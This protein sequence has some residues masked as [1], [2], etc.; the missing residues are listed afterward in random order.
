[1]GQYVQFWKVGGI[2]S[3]TRTFHYTRTADQPIAKNKEVFIYYLAS[4]QMIPRPEF[5]VNKSS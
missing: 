3:N 5:I 4:K 2:V 1:M